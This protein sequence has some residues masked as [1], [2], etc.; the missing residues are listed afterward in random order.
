MQ[1][2]ILELEK[3]RER[4]KQRNSKD[5]ML[6]V[7]YENDI[8][9]MRIHKRIKEANIEN[10]SD[11]VLNQMLLE[12]KHKVD[13]I[14]VKNYK[15]MDNEAFFHGSITPIIAKTSLAYNVKLTIEQIQFITNNVL[16]EYIEERKLAG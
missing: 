10:I 1:N 12:I 14:L 6:I 2:S 8:K 16:E 9:F 13:E 3:I 7:K 4:I 11:I 5:E 15:L